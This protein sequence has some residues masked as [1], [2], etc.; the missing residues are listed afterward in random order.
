MS[1]DPCREWLGIDA[2]D[3]ASPAKVLGVSGGESDPSVITT[4]AERRLTMLHAVDPG[5]FG[6]AHVAILERVLEARDELLRLARSAAAP[7]APPAEAPRPQFA[8]PPRPRSLAEGFASPVRPAASPRLDPTPSPPSPATP[9]PAAEATAPPAPPPVPPA[10]P[11]AA[12]VEPAD[13]SPAASVDPEGIRRPVVRRQASSS[14]TILAAVAFLAAAGIALAAY[15]A[16]PLPATVREREVA[17]RP[18]QPQAAP[19][20]RWRPARPAEAGV[21]NRRDDATAGGAATVERPRSEAT[22][23]PTAER[24]EAD[25]EAARLARER[26]EADAAQASRE[27]E[28]AE[29]RR[30]EAAAA[31]AAST[32][33]RSLGDALASLRRRD[34]AA[35]NRAVDVARK[36]AA[37]ADDAALLSR[38]QRWGLLVDYAGQLDDLVKQAI[39]AANA[40]RD[41]KIGNR[42]VSVIE[43]TP[44]SFV[45]KEAGQMKRGARAS[46]PRPVE[47]AILTTWFAGSPRPANHIFVGVHHLLEDRPDLGAVRAEWQKAL[48]GEEGTKSLMPLL[49]DPLLRTP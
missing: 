33:D 9:L 16:W 31:N 6:K 21:S 49:D 30:M 17:R 2:V 8:P 15:V 19:V 11:A 32:V 24:R 37:D 22:R 27:R 36:A 42:T 41:Y 40:G 7:P 47:R 35:A 12:I 1:F 4:A 18:A 23:R 10:V 29:R 43:I 38:A 45:Y 3:L 26:A 20:E 46:L 44:T 39:D 48:A 25:K 34:I 28:M 14:G 5:P 13:D